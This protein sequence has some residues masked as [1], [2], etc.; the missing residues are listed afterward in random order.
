[1]V[2]A[3]RTYNNTHFGSTYYTPLPGDMIL[4]CDD[5]VITSRSPI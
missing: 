3:E 4:F 1:M 5:I 2:L